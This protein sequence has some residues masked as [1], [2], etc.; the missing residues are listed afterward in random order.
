MIERARQDERLTWRMYALAASSAALATVF[1]ALSPV[2]ADDV[3]PGAPSGTIITL[4]GYG[5]LVPKFEGSK[6]EE[7][8][9][10]PII[11]WRKPG[12]RVWLDLPNDG[13][14]FE[15]IESDNF[16]AGAVGNIR[17]QRNTD[18][19]RPRGFKRVGSTDL[20]VEAGGFAEYWPNTGLRTRVEVRNSFIGADGVIADFSADAVFHPAERWT[21]TGGPRLSLADQSFMDSYYGVTATQ[22]ASAGLTPFKADAGI[23]SYGA[24]VSARYQWSPDLTSL[25]YVEYQR[26]AGSAGE[27]PLIDDRGSQDQITFGLGLKYSFR[28]DW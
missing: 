23:R 24:G 10:R 20:S 26:L 7:F 15:F 28:V 22:G 5:L 9:L 18:T 25:A 16:R 3:A 12:D 14:D 21:L 11:G 27:S 2:L 8:A 13:L 4:G 17:F 1:G 19:L 6:R